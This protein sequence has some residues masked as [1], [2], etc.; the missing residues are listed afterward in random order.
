MQ[1]ECPWTLSWL[2]R[3][4]TCGHKCLTTAPIRA[5]LTIGELTAFHYLGKPVPIKPS[6]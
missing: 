6:P 2:S 4:G 1:G 3:V 5:S